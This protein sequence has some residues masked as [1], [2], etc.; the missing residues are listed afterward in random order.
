MLARGVGQGPMAAGHVIAAIHG[1]KL[2]VITALSYGQSVEWARRTRRAFD[3][4]V[5]SFRFR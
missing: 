1:Q 2:Y 5:A 4:I 3:E